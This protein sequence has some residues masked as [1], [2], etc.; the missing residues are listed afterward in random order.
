MSWV[1][2]IWS[3]V[4][5]ACLTLAAMHL[6]VWCK[7]RAAW[8]SLA[9]TLAAL[10]VAGTAAGELLM[11]RSSTPWE[12]GFAIRLAYVPVA[13]LVMAL[14]GFVQLSFGN[15]R[16]WLAWTTAGL[17]GLALILNFTSGPNIIY[18]D[19]ASLRQIEFLGEAVSVVAQAVGNPWVRVD[20]LGN[21]FLLVFV[22]DASFRLWRSGAPENRRRALRVG[23]AILGFILVAAGYSALVDNRVIQSPYFISLPFLGLV[24]VMGLEL[25]DDVLR[26]NQLV[27]ELQHSQSHLLASR[28]EMDHQLRFERLVTEISAMLINIPPAEVE[29]RIVA[30]M[31]RV[32]SM[33]GFDIAVYSLLF[34][35]GT[36]LVA[37]VWNKP[38]V[39]GMP[40]H[41]TEKDFPWKARE[42]SEGRD[43]HLRTLDDFPPEA[44]VDR[45]T[46]ERYGIKSSSDVPIIVGGRGVGVFSLGSF[47]KEQ[48]VPP[49]IIQRQRIVGDLFA[50]AVLRGQA[51]AALR[52][53]ERRLDLAAA[54]ANLGL[55]FWK[56]QDN[57]LW[58]TDRAKEIFDFSPETRV[59]FEMWRE[60]LHPEDR[61]TIE[62]ELAEAIARRGAYDAE[63][64]ILRRDREVRWIAARGEVGFDR[65][66][67]PGSMTGVVMDITARKKAELETQE[68]RR[69]LAHS[70]RVTLLGQLASA[71]AHEL[72]QPLG[73]IMRNAEAAELILREHPPDLEELQAIV[74]DIRRDDQRAGDVISGLRSLLKRRELELHPVRLSGLIAEVVALVRADARE[75]GVR[76][77]VST[78]P[79]LPEV[80]GDRVH[81]QQVLL[82][83]LINAMDALMGS[84]TGERL[85]AIDS[86]SAPDGQ[87]MVSVSDNG[88]GIPEELLS[89]LFEPFFTTKA[90]GMGVGLAVSKNLIE[91]HQGKLWAENRPEGGAVFR[92]TVPM[93][94]GEGRGAREGG[95]E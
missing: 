57:S 80:Q 45:A 10:G 2:V 58:A 89:R 9:F 13:V 63:Y 26:A 47:E 6:L 51:D 35:Q 88:P 22:A 92:F 49:P 1:T 46:Y 28:M 25:S 30:A 44:A 95:M 59:T 70:S 18:L 52:E 33:L 40:A 20:E 19:I 77:E 50:N 31:G 38:G 41:L 73:A 24:V 69:D 87:V 53:S 64:R 27:G 86:V 60:R 48:A 12:M 21:L 94:R 39:A 75:R 91:A 66:G 43:T 74:T 23:G 76:V 90:S 79:G 62:A 72:G 78:A 85:I 83:L 54:A 93:A 84:R 8:G 14:V 15:G 55:W 65:E 56:M 37:Y 71:L 34:G 68:L 36:G 82:N 61:P 11:M 42:L 5:S 16:C 3:M 32:A 17:Q 4:A 29:K 81:L 7:N 67:K